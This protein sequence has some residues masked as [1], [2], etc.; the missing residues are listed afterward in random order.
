MPFYE[1]SAK[2]SSN[3]ISAFLEMVRTV[4]LQHKK[5]FDTIV[6]EREDSDGGEYI[7]ELLRENEE[8]SCCVLTW[9]FPYYVMD[10]TLLK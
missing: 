2:D 7:S 9:P 8:K 3:I 10:T 4:M 6:L 1:T 5:E